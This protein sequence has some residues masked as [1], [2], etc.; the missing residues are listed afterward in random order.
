MQGKSIY[1]FFLIIDL[2]SEALRTQI[3]NK[4]RRKMGN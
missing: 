4:Q 3:T 2:F 1:Y